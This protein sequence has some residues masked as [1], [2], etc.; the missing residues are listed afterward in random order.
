MQWRFWFRDFTFP[1]SEIPSEER[2]RKREERER[3]ERVPWNLGKTEEMNEC[4]RCG[5]GR[6]Y[7]IDVKRSV[8]VLDL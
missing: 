1:P 2:E 3:R 6:R 5:G 4:L 8:T 7:V